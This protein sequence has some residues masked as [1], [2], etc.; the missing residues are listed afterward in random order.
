MNSRTKTPL[1]QRIL[2]PLLLAATLITGSGCQTEEAER[3]QN[4]LEIYTNTAE[5]YYQLGDHD[6]AIA[7]AIK[8]LEIDP[9]SLKLKLILG[10][11]LQRRGKTQDVLHAEKIFRSVIDEPDFRAPLGLASSLE[12]QGVAYTEAADAVEG[13]HRI[14]DAPDP[15][16]RAEELRQRSLE[17]WTES[18]TWYEKTLALQK[19]NTEALNGLQ[20]VEAMLGHREAS[21]ARSAQLLEALLTDRGFWESQLTKA[22]IGD[23]QEREVRRM[24]NQFKDLEVATRQH[25]ARMEYELGHNDAAMKQLDAAI[26]L[27]PERADLH[28]LR[29]VVQ[30]DLGNW[31]QAIADAERFIALSPQGADGPDVKQ[32]FDLI[33]ACEAKRAR[34]KP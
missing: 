5:S 24:I 19:S 29:A 2:T 15:K 14:T 16:K 20:R 6:R 4:L 26:E 25:A 18:A 34:A 7:Q 33:G 31:D 1:P 11:S 8:A 13:G 17:L 10:W 30:R 23:S 27:N 28:G 9:D 12:R 22:Q 21:L 32:A 3:E